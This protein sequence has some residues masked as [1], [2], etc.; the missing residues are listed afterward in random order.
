MKSIEKQYTQISA[1]KTTKFFQ[2]KRFDEVFEEDTLV[3][4]VVFVIEALERIKLWSLDL[5]E[6]GYVINTVVIFI[7]DNVSFMNEVDWK[8]YIELMSQTDPCL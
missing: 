1:V 5:K 3:F 2:P 6:R 8:F 4:M 7:L